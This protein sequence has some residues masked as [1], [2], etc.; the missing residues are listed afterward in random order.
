MKK[1]EQGSEDDPSES[2]NYNVQSDLYLDWIEELRQELE[3]EGHV[4]SSA[5]SEFEVS[6]IYFN[7]R[8]RKISS[9]ARQV[10]VSAD[11]SCPPTL[12]NGLQLLR[13]KMEVGDDLTP[14]LSR[15]LKKPDYDDLMLNDWGIYHF[16]LGTKIEAD[17][18]IERTGPV[19]YA[20]VTRDTVY[21]IS[22]ENHGSWT[23]QQLMEV[24]HKN[25]P[26][27]LVEYKTGF[28][29]MSFETTENDRKLF[30][31]WG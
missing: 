11:F 23:D 2:S 6:C 15:S 1:E 25:W 17:G 14:H 24:I 18:F 5:L 27:S 19:L 16:H 26:D 4:V 13:S 30:A 12:Q 10:F 7:L 3:S 21:F 9:R 31:N 20:R 29:D 28:L 8:K 22:V